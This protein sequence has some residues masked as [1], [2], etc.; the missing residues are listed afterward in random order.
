[1]AHE[2]MNMDVSEKILLEG[3]RLDPGNIDYILTLMTVK[4][5]QGDRGAATELYSLAKSLSPRSTIFSDSGSAT[6]TGNSPSAD[7][8]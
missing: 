6:A 3:R 1:M 8:R 2:H 7:W 5:S 4:W